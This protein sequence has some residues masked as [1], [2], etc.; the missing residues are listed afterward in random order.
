MLG[1]INTEIW[2]NTLERKEN[3]NV[4]RKKENFDYG[5]KK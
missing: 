1:I 3:K 2:V 4:I 5:N